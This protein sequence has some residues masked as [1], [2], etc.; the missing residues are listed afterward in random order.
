M[1]SPTVDTRDRPLAGIACKILGTIFFALMF[2]AIRWLGPYFPV[3][4]IVFFRSFLGIPVIVAAALIS[5]RPGLLATRRVDSHAFRSLAGTASMI[6]S[7]AGYTYLPLADATAIGFAA[8]LFVVVLAA[9]M[10]GERVRLYRWSAVA[11]GFAGVLII[12]GPDAS[13]ASGMAIGAA[14]ALLGAALNAFAMIFLRRMSTHEHSI[15]IA[16]YFMVTSSAVGLASLIFGWNRP[17]LAE[18][19]ILAFTGLAGG[20][21]QLF[22]SYSYR[23]SEASVLAPF[24]Y[25]ALIWAVAL[26]YLFFAELPGPAV[27]LGAAIVTATGLF[28]L[29][30]ERRLGKARAA[31]PAL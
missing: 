26:G 27:Y 9:T 5:G 7:F 19:A 15:T 4:E 20:I 23:Y 21:G 8:P 28:I 10:L 31:A 30:R 3:G 22:L 25:A 11:L 6:C 24:D 14:F 13:V 29:W 18:A 17:T 1:E 2:A 16:F 12:A